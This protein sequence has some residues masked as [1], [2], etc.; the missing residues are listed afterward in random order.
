MHANGS[1]ELLTE[2]V[3]LHVSNDTPSSRIRRVSSKPTASSPASRRDDMHTHNLSP[4]ANNAI[5]REVPPMS[6]KPKPSGQ[7]SRKINLPRSTTLPSPNGQDPLADEI[8]DIAHKRGERKEKQSRNW[9]K[10]RAMHEKGELERLLEELR[11]PDWLKLMGI[12]GVSETEVKRLKEKRNIFITRAR[13][14]LERYDAWRERDK[15]L[16]L[17]RDRKL[18]RLQESS[19]SEPDSSRASAALSEDVAD[20]RSIQRDAKSREPA[21]SKQAAP[22]ESKPFTSFFEKP[23][24][25][26]AALKGYRRGRHA[27][28][29]G[30]P[31][32]DLPEISEFELPPEVMEGKSRYM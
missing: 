2:D 22:P 23:H 14:M 32:P 16:K 4:L 19:V 25:R 17:E 9:D 29:F 1:V 26:E 18:A 20:T 11:G 6:N 10:E 13:T 21:P 28:A 3:R 27:L 31:I 15:E 7:L 24:L 5:T 30:H 12:S 8:Y